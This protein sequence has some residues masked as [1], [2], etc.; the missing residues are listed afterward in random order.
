MTI[1]GSDAASEPYDL[2][3][4]GGNVVDAQGPR[5]VDLA[6]RGGRVAAHLG[7]G[8]P[9]TALATLDVGGRYI[10]PGLV[11]AH[12]HLREPGLT[13]KEDFA[14]GT[15]AAAAGGVTTILDMPTDEPWTDTAATLRDK[16][17]LTRDRLRVDTAFQVAVRRDARD[18]RAMRDEGAVSFEIF[19]ADVPLP[20]RH[21]TVDAIA[22]AMRK[23]ADCDG[24]AGLQPSD[25]SLLQAGI[26]ADDGTIAGYGASRPPLA[27]AMGVAH[28]VLA[29]ADT[30]ARVHVRQI[31]AMP[32]LD[33]WRRLRERADVTIET[34]VQNLLLTAERYRDLGAAIKASPPFREEADRRA[35][36]EAIRNGSIDMV[37]TDHAPHTPAEKQ[38]HA[39]FSDV[40]GGLPGLQTLLFCMLY[41]V[42]RGDLRLADVVRLCAETPAQRFALPRKGSLAVGCDADLLVLAPGVTSTIGDGVSFSKAGL[43]PFAG[44]SMPYGLERVLLRGRTIWAGGDLSEGAS[45]VVLRPNASEAKAQAGGPARSVMRRY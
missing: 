30:R 43:S 27:E 8:Q 9:A 45:G 6:V 37:V 40:P 19:T 13:H 28:A 23:V 33:A 26:R 21:D 2:V 38:G 7:R 41:L 34:S 22:A 15:M 24:L 32:A 42:D 18:L 29:A 16:L 12:T 1:P 39:R 20:Y 3:L 5:A 25:E 14:T 4:R 31:G 17:K 11:D 10:L 36:I 44:L 35:L